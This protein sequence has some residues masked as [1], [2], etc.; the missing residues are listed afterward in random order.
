MEIFMTKA[1]VILANGA[2]DIETISVTDI[3]TRG[4]IKV[5][6]AALSNA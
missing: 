4:G 3:L 5:T 6:V 1:L 2:E